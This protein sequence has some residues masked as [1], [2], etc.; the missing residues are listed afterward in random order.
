MY[1]L[2]ILRLTFSLFPLIKGPPRTRIRFNEKKKIP[3]LK[4]FHVTPRKIKQI[5][6]KFYL[7]NFV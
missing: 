4:E 6:E 3:P 1:P 2:H 7:N 5:R